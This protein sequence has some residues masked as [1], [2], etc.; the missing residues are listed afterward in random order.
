[1]S[2]EPEGNKERN[3]VVL[4]QMTVCPLG[5]ADRAPDAVAP[6]GQRQLIGRNRSG[7]PRARWTLHLR[8]GALTVGDN[9][10]IARARTG[11]R[12]GRVSGA[13]QRDDR[14][15]QRT[16]GKGLPPH[17]GAS[18]PASVKQIPRIC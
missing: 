13:A 16:P 14:G 10:R 4:G 18:I 3:P 6:G 11:V 7:R 5:T 12:D 15:A 8:R 17:H 9:G 1:M 2:S